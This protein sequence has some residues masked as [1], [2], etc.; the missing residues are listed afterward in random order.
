MNE[1]DHRDVQ[2]TTDIWLRMKCPHWDSGESSDWQFFR[3]V[4]G[5]EAKQQPQVVGALHLDMSPRN[6]RCVWF[7]S[8]LQTYLL[9]PGL[10]LTHFQFP[11]VTSD[12]ASLSSICNLNCTRGRTRWSSPPHRLSSHASPRKCCLCTCALMSLGSLDR[13]TGPSPWPAAI[14]F[15]PPHGVRLASQHANP[16]SCEVTGS[17]FAYCRPSCH[18]D[19]GSWGFETTS[20]PNAISCKI[21]L[22]C[23]H[24][25]I[26]RSLEYSGGN[27]MTTIQSPPPL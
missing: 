15:L 20:I 8:A 27:V 17:P 25:S 1:V 23:Y 26:C 9:L 6:F 16:G 3:G 14:W 19:N 18:G 11:K 10:T 13:V 12:A 22:N 4:M 7:N 21:P 5:S 24:F 2:E